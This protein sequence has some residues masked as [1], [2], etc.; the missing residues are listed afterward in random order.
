MPKELY[1]NARIIDGLGGVI[2]NGWVLVS[3]DDIEAVGPHNGGDIPSGREIKVV[4]LA[5]RTIVPGLIDCHVHLLMEGDP[6]PVAKARA[7]AEAEAVLR[8]ANNGFRT[9]QAGF[10]TVRDMG[11]KKLYR[12]ALAKRLGPGPGRR[13]ASFLLRTDDLHHRRP[14][15]RNRTGGRRS[16]RGPQGGQ[17]SGRGRRG[18]GLN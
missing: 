17:G 3:G 12:R 11:A 13:P 10:T 16:G 4:D 9:L 8:M 5:G 2:E 7:S 1:K 6:D 15:C 18:T 14:R